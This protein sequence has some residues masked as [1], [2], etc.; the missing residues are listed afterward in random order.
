MQ[1]QHFNFNSFIILVNVFL[2]YYNIRLETFI[3][4]LR[5]LSDANTAL[6]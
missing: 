3:V 6:S 1:F 2:N 5:L 4:D